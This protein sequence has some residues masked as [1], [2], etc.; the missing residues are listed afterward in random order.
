MSLSPRCTSGEFN[1]W[2]L[3][4]VCASSALM[5]ALTSPGDDIVRVDE[6]VLVGEIAMKEVVELLDDLGHERLGSLAY[7]A[8]ARGSDRLESLCFAVVERH[9]NAGPG[10][11]R[12]VSQHHLRQVDAFSFAP[13][14]Q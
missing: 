9:R 11:D 2:V 12:V 4:A 3:M 13:E 8:A 5:M 6:L 14:L 10:L 1:A 7:Q